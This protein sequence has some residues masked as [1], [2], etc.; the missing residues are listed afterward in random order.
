[1]VRSRE[2]IAIDTELALLVQAKRTQ[3]GVSLATGGSLRTIH[4][5]G[6]SLRTNKGEL[7]ASDDEA[8]TFPPESQLRQDDPPWGIIAYR[9]RVKNCPPRSQDDDTDD[10]TE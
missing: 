6:S 3:E 8:D 7:I 1:M 10:A 4:P 2:M 5:D 9:N